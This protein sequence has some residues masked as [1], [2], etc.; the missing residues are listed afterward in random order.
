MHPIPRRR[1]RPKR[2]KDR[3]IKA[4]AVCAG[5]L[6]LTIQPARGI[7]ILISAIGGCRCEDDTCFQNDRLHHDARNVH[8][9]HAHARKYRQPGPRKL[10]LSSAAI[11]PHQ[12]LTAGIRMDAG[13]FRLKI[14]YL[15]AI[16]YIKNIDL[17]LC[18][19]VHLFE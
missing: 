14:D 9:A 13:F 18:K 19:G 10:T 17:K 5:A 15:A 16:W 8:H 11:S 2:P 3:P 6:F 1:H 4:P 12:P 7:I